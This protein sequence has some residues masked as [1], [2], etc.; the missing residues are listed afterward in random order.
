MGV[1]QM[2]A[3]ALRRRLEHGPSHG[4]MFWGAGGRRCSSFVFEI[5]G[6]MCL[7]ILL[8]K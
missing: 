7:E 2:T 3:M 1:L 8:L 6:H 4:A 5:S